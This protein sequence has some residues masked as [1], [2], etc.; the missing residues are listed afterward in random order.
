MR[1]V[2]IRPEEIPVR[3]RCDTVRIFSHRPKDMHRTERDRCLQVF[4]QKKD[5]LLLIP[6]QNLSPFLLTELTYTVQLQHD[7]AIT[8]LHI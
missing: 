2:V 6:H 4:L 1:A 7:A 8:M 5:K 3:Q